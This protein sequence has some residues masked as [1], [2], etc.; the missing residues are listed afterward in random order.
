MGAR[1]VKVIALNFSAGTA[2]FISDVEKTKA[3]VREFGT[4][5]GGNMKEFG[6]H[7][8]S[9]MSAAS[10]ALRE[11]E[12][13]FTHN[14][15]A[16]ERFLGTTLGLGPILQK[17]FP[18]VG[19]LAFAGVVV[20]LGTKVYEF[21]KE[22]SDAP[23]KVAGA[24]RA[25]NDPLQTSNDALQVSIDKVLQEIDKLQGR[26]TNTLKLELDEA[27]ESADK[28]RESL[29]KSLNSLYKL[30]SENELGG[31]KAFFTGQAATSD[32][33]KTLGGRT[34][35]G[36]DIGEIDKIV[37]SYR[38]K[39]DAVSTVEEKNKQRAEA[40]VALEQKFNSLIEARNREI[41]ASR[42]LAFTPKT[43][44]LTG[45]TTGID[46]SLRIE[47][48]EGEIRTIKQAARTIPL[49]FQLEDV[50]AK[51][52]QLQTQISN[53]K[54]GDLIAAK[55]KL[56]RDALGEAEAKLSSVG[57]TD[58]FKGQ[59]LGAAAA[60]KA[61]DELDKVLWSRYRQHL[62]QSTRDEITSLEIK[63]KTTEAE[64]AWQPKLDAGTREIQNRINA[65]NALTAAIGKGY[66]AT[67]AAS[68]GVQLASFF[69]RELNDPA[70]EK[71]Q[72][73]V[74]ARI[75]AE[76][77]AKHREQIAQTIDRLGDQA[78]LEQSLL[79]VQQMG[80][81]AIGRVTLA[82]RLRDLVSKG[83]T[84]EQIALEVQLFEIQQKRSTK[85]ELTSINQQIAATERLIAAQAQGAEVERRAALENKYTALAAGGAKPEVIEAVRNQD[86]V[87][88][89]QKVTAEA[90]K[91][92]NAY[93][94]ALQS[95][96][97]QLQVLDR[98]AATEQN[99]VDLAIRRR[100]IEDGIRQAQ[101]DQA[102]KVGTLQDGMRAFFTDMENQAEKPGKIMYDGMKSAVDKI[103][104]NLAELFTGGTSDF[105]K[106]FQ[107]IG[108]QMAESSIKAELS[109]GLGLLGG[110][111]GLDLQKRDGQ[112]GSTA[113]WVQM[114][115]GGYGQNGSILPG[116]IGVTGP[117]PLS[118]K[119]GGLDLGGLFGG[120]SKG[121]GIFSLVSSFFGKRAAKS[122]LGGISADDLSQLANG[123]KSGGGLFDLIDWGSLFAGEY[124]NGGD[125]PAGAYG[126]AGEHGPEP[127][128]GPAHVMS[129]RDFR[130]AGGGDIHVHIGNMDFRQSQLGVE[131][132]VNAAMRRVHNM[133]VVTSLKASEE[134]ARRRPQRG[135]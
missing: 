52:T 33:K 45:G 125:I 35:A 120:G 9:S 116:I 119:S 110:K 131:S 47:Q 67:K 113:L 117:P 87:D 58:A 133:A 15:R 30:L 26:H 71:G 72:A 96:K 76:F 24:F 85:T 50:T 53:E 102:L 112:S 128:F 4:S 84:R 97:E 19:A 29:D 34:G 44:N 111:L 135:G 59:V 109:K 115:G 126:I 83:A 81:E 2:E 94:D 104:S 121:V 134:Q 51:K 57:Q 63:T 54:P 122:S 92:V 3:K 43:A 56:L 124:A 66:E 62:S 61:I 5:A 11:L 90:L 36:G 69:G 107:E 70:R 8:V 46:P 98:I 86:E 31:F 106:A 60:A 7:A 127:V 88:H 68:V 40:R 32:L 38:D 123:G 37:D 14:I 42:Q 20:E 95:L 75:E 108:K 130:G 27:K 13:N 77:E 6:G 73:E 105:G 17:A 79:E 132:Q 114:A 41:E 1:A 16:A 28:L 82:Y 103:S 65:S 129:N 91:G 89:R 99:Q 23:E 21:V 18:V 74:K 39:L 25:L 80:A 10:G 64:T 78:E 49:Q 55:L 118:G 12:G 48:L 22:L 93:R 100:E 101:I